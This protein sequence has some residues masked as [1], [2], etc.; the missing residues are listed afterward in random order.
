MGGNKEAR[1]VGWAGGAVESAGRVAA[2]DPGRLGAYLGESARGAVTPGITS[3]GRLSAGAALTV[4]LVAG[5]DPDPGPEVDCGPGMAGFGAG[6]GGSRAGG[7]SGG[8]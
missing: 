3:N 5:R 7:V 2:T 4:G 1:E 8:A 6:D